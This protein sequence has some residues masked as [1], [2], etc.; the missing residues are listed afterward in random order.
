MSENPHIL[1]VDDEPEI[2]ALI[3]DAF[4]DA[5][6][7]MIPCQSGEKAIQLLDQ[8]SFS[9]VITDL[10]MTPVDG[11]EVL[12][13]AKR[14]QPFCEIVMITGFAS[15]DSSLAALRGKVF[16][17]L[18]KPINL[19]QL[20]RTL[21]N[22]VR[23]NELAKENADLVQRL[24]E[25]NELLE[26][27]VEEATRELQDLTIRDYLTSLYNYRFFVSALTTEVS[28]SVRYGRPLSL[29]MLDIDHFKN[30]NDSL[31]HLAGNQVLRT[32]AHILRSLVRENDVVVRYGGEEFA[33][34][35]PETSKSE[36]A[37]IISRIQKAIRDRHFSYTIPSG[38]KA[39]LTISAGIADCPGDADDF[40]SLVRRADEALYQAKNT[41]RDKLILA[42][43]RTSV[44]PTHEKS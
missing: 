16:D 12:R 44:K 9:A 33:I 32:L 8:I 11:L 31:G 34:I 28:R 6:Y 30:Y 39:I 17:Y 10:C 24:N 4:Q 23:K 37:P 21:Q 26:R 40:D 27:Q 41:G 19:E 2:V 29:V 1:V 25:Q 7:E 14:M 22:A 18:E 38:A 13:Q 43:T 36:A 42:A 35:L 15:I 5:P 3:L 20:G